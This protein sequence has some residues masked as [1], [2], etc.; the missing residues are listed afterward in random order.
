MGETMDMKQI[1]KLEAIPSGL[2]VRELVPDD[3]KSS[4]IDWKSGPAARRLTIAKINQVID[5]VTKLQQIVFALNTIVMQ[6]SQAMVEQTGKAEGG[7]DKD[8]KQD[9]AA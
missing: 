1:A 3:G 4:Q 8:S 6:Q 9:S 5:E 7:D 2:R